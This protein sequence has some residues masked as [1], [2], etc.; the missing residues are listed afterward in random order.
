MPT[1]LVFIPE[2]LEKVNGFVNG[3]HALT[4]VLRSQGFSVDAVANWVGPK[5]MPKEFQRLYDRIYYPR[6][7]SPMID[8]LNQLI[9]QHY[10]FIKKRPIGGRDDFAFPG[11]VLASLQ[12]YDLYVIHHIPL[13]WVKHFLPENSSKIL[14]A[15]YYTS[16][17]DGMVNKETA[18]QI[19]RNLREEITPCT[20]YDLVTVTGDK[21]KELFLKYRPE[22]KVVH[23]PHYT[24][25]SGKRILRKNA[26]RIIATG[27][28]NTSNRMGV[29]F[30]IRQVYPTLRKLDPEVE[31]HVTSNICAYLRLKG[32]DRLPGVVLHGYVADLN[33]IYDL[34]DVLLAI[35]FHSEGVKTR[36]FEAF[37]LGIPVVTTT[38]GLTNTK[39]R[40]GREAVVVDDGPSMARAIV[41]TLKSLP[42]RKRLQKNGYDYIRRY[43]DIASPSF[44]PVKKAIREILS[45]PKSKQQAVATT[46][47][48]AILQIKRELSYLACWAVNRCNEAGYKKV[49]FFG[50]GAHTRAL[51]SRWE[52]CDGPKVVCIL[53]STPTDVK[54]INRIPIV[55][56]D[57][58]DSQKVDAIVASSHTYEA[59]MA[60]I[61][62][63]KFPKVPFLT[64]WL[65]Q[66][67]GK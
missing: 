63:K 60:E 50:A 28:D 3:V 25:I 36:L 44:L 39:I 41:K 59:E 61:C 26:H 7:H 33:K 65:P 64:I 55:T 49:A 67:S 62:R 10:A 11:A 4:R 46:G 53:S 16:V 13:D 34:C 9:R 31:F 22:A 27:Y 57:H 14:F 30:F 24:P 6:G 66:A 54:S 32:Y 5:G 19:Q 58:F 40:P 56:L 23:L 8:G 43:H 18:S 42:L 48:E 29:D 52:E 35:I 47:R 2:D 21:D 37:G 45:C 38:T 1:A 17:V 20:D 51:L 15:H 12:E